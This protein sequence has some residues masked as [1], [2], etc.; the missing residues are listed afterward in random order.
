MLNTPQKWS[1]LDVVGFS[2]LIAQLVASLVLLARVPSLDFS[3]PV[4]QASAA[5]ILSTL[6]IVSIRAR[7]LRGS[8]AERLLLALFLGGMPLVYVGSWFRLQQ[9]GWLWIELVGTCVFVVLAV[10]GWRRSA[11]FLA[12]GIL[13]HGLL[14]D[15]PHHA[16]QE[17]VPTWYTLGCLIV[18]VGMAIYAAVEVPWFARSTRVPAAALA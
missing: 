16:R 14:W 10:L 15:L 1:A 2:A 18:D 13:A 7:G 9:P 11:W 4:V 17:F 3:V 6:L 8:R 12:G 5:G